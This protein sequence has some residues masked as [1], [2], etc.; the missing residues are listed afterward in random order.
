L[1]R[2]VTDLFI[3]FN[4][5]ATHLY[6]TDTGTTGETMT[7]T[8]LLYVGGEPLISKTMCQK[9]NSLFI[10]N[11][12]LLRPNAGS[13]SVGEVLLKDIFKNNASVV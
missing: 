7:A 10:G 4:N 3:D 5:A 13:L 6:Y 12:K 1:I 2:K 9:D 11:I 8:H